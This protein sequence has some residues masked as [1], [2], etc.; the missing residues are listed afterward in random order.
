MAAKKILNRELNVNETRHL[1]DLTELF[2]QTNSIIFATT[3]TEICV[4]N[5]FFSEILPN[6]FGKFFDRKISNKIDKVSFDIVEKVE[7]LSARKNTGSVTI[8]MNSAINR[9]QQ[10]VNIIS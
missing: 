8:S 2:Q 5:I 9:Y 1:N 7:N 4:A 10:E 3:S 6:I